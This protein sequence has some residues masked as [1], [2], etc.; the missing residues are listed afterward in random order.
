MKKKLG[1]KYMLWGIA[2]VGEGLVAFISG[3][4]LSFL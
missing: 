4:Y 3:T 1:K 2:D